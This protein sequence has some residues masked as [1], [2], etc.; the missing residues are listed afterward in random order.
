MT[1]V[2]LV[3]DVEF[4]GDDSSFFTTTIYTTNISGKLT[5]AQ[6]DELWVL[7]VMVGDNDLKRKEVPEF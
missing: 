1:K 6:K 3:V 4:E 5:S 2:R 7:S